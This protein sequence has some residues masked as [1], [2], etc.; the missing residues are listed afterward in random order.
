MDLLVDAANRYS[1]EAAVRNNTKSLHSNSHLTYD[2]N[3]KR[4]LESDSANLAKKVLAWVFFARRPVNIRVIQEAISLQKSQSQIAN[5]LKSVDLLGSCFGLVVEGVSTG[6]AVAFMHPDMERY[7]C[8]PTTIQKIRDWLPDGPRHV[9]SSCLQA[10]VLDKDAQSKS[11]LWY[12]AA[13][14]WSHHIRDSYIEFEP[15]I[16]KFLSQPDKV[17]SAMRYLLQQPLQV[18]AAQ[19]PELPSCFSRQETMAFN[20]LCG[21]PA[22]S[23][24]NGWHAAAY[25]GLLQRFNT[26]SRDDI[27]SVDG[28]GWTPLWWAILGKQNKVVEL[29]L[30]NGAE[31]A[32]KSQRGVPL[33][34]WMLGKG[35][36]RITS[37]VIKNL[38]VEKGD[39]LTIG[40]LTQLPAEITYF[41]LMQALGY[42]AIEI[43][44][45]ES[46]SMVIK[47]LSTDQ[48]NILDPEG[49]TILMTAAKFWQWNIVHH[50]LGRGA[51]KSIR[52][53]TGETAFA[54][55]LK[56]RQER[57]D[58]SHLHVHEG[59]RFMMGPQIFLPPQTSIDP[60]SFG[61]LETTIELMMLELMPEKLDMKGEEGAHALRLAIINRHSRLVH[62]LLKNGASPNTVYKD[63]LTPLGL[64]CMQPSFSLYNISNAQIDKA[65][66][67]HIGAM[68]SAKPKTK[69]EKAVYDEDLPL[70]TFSKAAITNLHITKEHKPIPT[71]FDSIVRMLLAKGASINTPSAGQTPL[72]MA[73]EAEYF[74]IFKTLLTGGA[75]IA[76]VGPSLLDRFIKLLHVD[77][78]SH[79]THN[80]ATID[81]IQDFETHDFSNFLLGF[82]IPG[83]LMHLENSH[84]ADDSVNIFSNLVTTKQ[85]LRLSSVQRPELGKWTAQREYE[86]RIRNKGYT[87]RDELLTMIAKALK[88][89]QKEN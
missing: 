32:I 75:N 22:P 30:Q 18:V 64:A 5:M 53:N 63:G 58:I 52:N 84:L 76:E 13:E 45:P 25:F 6:G 87:E 70:T 85:S 37:H 40:T 59:A 9:A 48:L 29:L 86:E 2:E 16:S 71:T 62:Q 38:E 47:T 17:T 33:V 1:T 66:R 83:R 60:Y 36:K 19:I 72:A 21:H 55:S 44:T 39:P 15:E 31:T 56:D 68:V 41:D 43:A 11:Q 12:Y 79:N 28:N 3:I 26:A 14:H 61:E 74:S 73:A 46:I 35:W 69:Y 8:E 10:L 51:N 20:D 81:M 82:A 34:V 23:K 77:V 57:Y 78:N 50:L 54:L 89:S 42:Y 4:I 24:C 27:R 80:N 67:V 49:N 65:A 7:F 88:N